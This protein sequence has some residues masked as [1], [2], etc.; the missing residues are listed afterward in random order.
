MDAEIISEQIKTRLDPI[1]EFHLSFFRTEDDKTL[2]LLNIRQGE[3][4][5]YYYLA[6]EFQRL[7]YMERKMG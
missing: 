2:I 5:S 3:E 7:G 6:D 1:P 4:T